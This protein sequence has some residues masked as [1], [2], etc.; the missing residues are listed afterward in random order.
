VRAL[1]VRRAGVLALAVCALALPIAERTAF[2]QPEVNAAEYQ[3]KAAYLFKFLNYVDWPEQAV[4]DT[5]LQIGVIGA[6][7]MADELTGIVAKRTVNGRPVQVRRLRPGEA[8]GE[9]N[10]L[11]VARSET[12]RL[13]GIVAATKDQGTL[14]VTESTEAPALGSAINF[15]VEDDR[16]RFDVAPRAFERANL[17]V[18]ARLLTVARRVLPGSS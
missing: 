2:A 5:P 1:R 17:K 7:A 18:S 10:L 11:F 14:V 15:V 4:A 9:L 16:V 6:R 8:T 12:A 3:I 13:A